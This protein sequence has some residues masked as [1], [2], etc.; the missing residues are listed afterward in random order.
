MIDTIVPIS[1]NKSRGGAM[2]IKWRLT[3]AGILFFALCVLSFAIIEGSFSREALGAS[4]FMGG[5]IV[6]VGW[7]LDD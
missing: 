3:I 2:T 5:V 4:L 7:L 6:G 1:C